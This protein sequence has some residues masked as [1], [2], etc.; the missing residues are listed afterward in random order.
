MTDL[1]EAIRVGARQGAQQAIEDNLDRILEKVLLTRSRPKQKVTVPE[2]AQHLRVHPDTLR[3]W[4]RE[5]APAVSQ[6]GRWRVDLH[7]LESWIA[8]KPGKHSQRGAP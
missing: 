3:R 4:I 7:E 8:T 6:G 5:G 2:A 1:N